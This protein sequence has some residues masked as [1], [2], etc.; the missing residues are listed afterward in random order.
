G[1]LV[2]TKIHHGSPAADSRLSV[3]DELLFLDNYRLIPADAQ[4][5][6]DSRD[7]TENADFVVSRDGIMRTFRIQ[8]GPPPLDSITLVKLAEPTERQKQLYANWLGAAWE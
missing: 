4:K 8:P 7:Q 3:D 5:I 1:N 6:M 2:I